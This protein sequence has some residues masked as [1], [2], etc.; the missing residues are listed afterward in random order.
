MRVVC[1]TERSLLSHDEFEAVRLGHHPAVYGLARD[2]L[3]GLIARLR[4]MRD[5]ERTFVRARR[6]R[7]RGKDR[8]R[9]DSFP[10]TADRPQERDQ[11]FTAAM[12]RLDEE[13]ERQRAL[14]AR[15]TNAEAARRALALRRAQA[16]VPHPAG[17]D[18]AL[19]GVA[20]IPSSRRRHQ[21]APE[22]IGRVSQ[23]TKVRQAARDA[24]GGRRDDR[25]GGGAVDGSAWTRRPRARS[26]I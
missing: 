14:A 16:F 23:H 18:S 1:R 6:R 11:I 8:G 26:P 7:A 4:A 17:G 25:R 2:E 13:R 24:C 10:G 3:L 22:R 15:T 9:G 12:R 19:G 5:Q 21:I 20:S